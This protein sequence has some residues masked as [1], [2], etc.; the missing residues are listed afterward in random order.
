MG[1]KGPKKD[2]VKMNAK[3]HAKAPNLGAAPKVDDGQHIVPV[4]AEAAA[5]AAE[6]DGR[7]SRGTAAF[8]PTS[9]RRFSDPFVYARQESAPGPGAYDPNSPRERARG[10]GVDYARSEREAEA[11]PRP[12]RAAPPPPAAEDEILSDED[13]VYDVAPE[14]AA[15]EPTVDSRHEILGEPLSP[16]TAAAR[17]RY[18]YQVDEPAADEPEADE[19]AADEPE[20]DEPEADE[21]EATA[22]VKTA[23]GGRGAAAPA[24]GA[25]PPAREQA[26]PVA[27]GTMMVCCVPAMVG[28]LVLAAGASLLEQLRLK[29]APEASLRLLSPA[30]P[31]PKPKEACAAGAEGL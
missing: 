26:S 2:F 17:T 13:S 25:A 15:W 22:V 18:S 5:A 10:G 27:W 7:V 8:A 29:D 1:R 14:G 6:D 30:R 31:G 16:R 12:E 24:A 21:P 3:H 9:H 23:P 4:S 11:R 28:G 19:P 20:A